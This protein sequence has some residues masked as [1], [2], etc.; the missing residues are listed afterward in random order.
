MSTLQQTTDDR[1]SAAAGHRLSAG[2]PAALPLGAHLVTRRRGY[3]HH[4]IYVGD[5]KVVHYAGL[6]RSW[7]RGPVE[8]VSIERFAAGRAV[9]V[10]P[11]ANARYGGDEIVR[12]ARSRLGEDR[13]R[14]VRNN[15]EHFC[16]WC[17]RGEA[18]SEQVEKFLAAPLLA[19]LRALLRCYP[20]LARPFCADPVPSPVD[21][22][23]A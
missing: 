9:L 15:C 23:A 17:I 14:I 13:Y 20:S 18:R 11:A 1:S 16:E 4:G 19:P 21:P 10:K 6:S 3:R 12:R 2:D 22:C 8:E 5:G 7:H